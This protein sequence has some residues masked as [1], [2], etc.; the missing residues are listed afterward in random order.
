MAA[1]KPYAMTLKLRTPD[2]EIN[3]SGD[4]AE[5]AEMA[6]KYAFFFV[7]ADKRQAV[8]DHLRDRIAQELIVPNPSPAKDTQK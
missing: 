6:V 5:G 1:K 7:P 2:G 8:L 4:G 3:L